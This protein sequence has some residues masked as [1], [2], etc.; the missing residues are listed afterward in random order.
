MFN[1]AV[2]QNNVSLELDA[3]VYDRHD[4]YNI[5]HLFD[6]ISVDQLSAE[7]LPSCLNQQEN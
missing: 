2:L 7:G 3:S 6:A 4:R 5:D 1:R